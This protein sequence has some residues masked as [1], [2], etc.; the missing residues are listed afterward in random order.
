[1]KLNEIFDTNIP[2]IDVNKIIA[3]A[4]SERAK[5]PANSLSKREP[6]STLLVEDVSKEEAEKLMEE[7][8]AEIAKTISRFHQR[9]AKRKT[10][11]LV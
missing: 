10:S 6:V 7:L 9:L 5:Y 2:C 11:K 8:N 3:N 4:L 1:M